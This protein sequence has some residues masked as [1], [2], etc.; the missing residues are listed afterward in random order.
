MP[1]VISAKHCHAYWCNIYSTI[2]LYQITESALIDINAVT[3]TVLSCH[4]LAIVSVRHQ[5]VMEQQIVRFV[6]S[7]SLIRISVHRRAATM[8]SV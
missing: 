1:Y 3:T 8:N 2:L 4:V 7:H 6:S 5:T